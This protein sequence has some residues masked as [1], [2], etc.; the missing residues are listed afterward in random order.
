M[1]FRP[2]LFL[3]FISYLLSSRVMGQPIQILDARTQDKIAFVHLVLDDSLDVF[4]D[5]EGKYTFHKSWYSVCLK[6]PYYQTACFSHAEGIPDTIFLKPQKTSTRINRSDEASIHLIKSI[7]MRRESL[8]LSTQQ[9]SYKSYNKFTLSGEKTGKSN[10]FFKKILN[11]LSY[12]LESFDKVHLFL[13]ESVSEKHHKNKIYYK[14]KITGL[15]STGIK[16]PLTYTNL[17][18]PSP[19]TIYN[20]YIS[21][22]TTKYVS[23]LCHAGYVTYA[24][25]IKDTAVIDG[26]TLFAVRFY[27]HPA[28]SINALQGYL[29]IDKKEQVVRYFVA[30]PIKQGNVKFEAAEEFEKKEGKWVPYIYRTDIIMRNFEAGKLKLTAS[31]KSIIFDYQFGT[32][33]E[34]SYFNEYVLEYD[35][36]ATHVT[37]DVWEQYRQME[38]TAKD[39]A[40]F[41]FFDST[42]IQKKQDEVLKFGERVYYGEIPVGKINLDLNR[43]I[44]L[45]YLEGLRLGLGFHTNYKFSP[46]LRTGG[47]FGYGFKDQKW[48]YGADISYK[49]RNPYELSLGV[50]VRHDI[51]EAGAQFFPFDVY[52]YSSEPLRKYKL[53]I[54]DY[55]NESSAYISFRPLKYLRVNTALTIAENLPAYRY[56]YKDMQSNRFAYTELSAGFRYSFGEQYIKT[57]SNNL[58]I[59]SSYPIFWFNYTRG[60]NDPIWGQ[61]SYSRFDFKL[62]QTFNIFRY[63]TSGIQL[64][65][66]I[67]TGSP[68]YSKLYN[69]RGSF[70]EFS[71]VIH[72]SFETM[73]YNEFLSD[74]FF[75]L[76]YSHDFGKIYSPNPNFRPNIVMVH[77]FGFG[78]LRHP[79]YQK[80]IPF[81]TMQKGFF[82]SGVFLKNLMIINL[83]G[84]RTG[85]GFGVFSRYG[86]YAAKKL[87]RNI[88][89]K[90]SANFLI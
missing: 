90:L 50:S 54:L 13:L 36:T 86:P 8:Q 68:P 4:S 71:V 81:K 42:G 35:S 69:M 44:N 39:S 25:Q 22:A 31:A 48:K 64:V 17:L 43:I 58:Y 82:E 53:S 83:S 41:Y 63:G 45:N 77:N 19:F 62:Q 9:F 66:G 57:P 46:H 10:K 16:L 49:F 75:A 23:P 6:S 65:A 76:F 29:Y 70:R 55:I 18:H 2:S 60:I 20:N 11:L 32:T 80:L 33:K 40:T 12:D 26:D 28:R 85:L 47:Y 24:Y 52:Q 67:T 27:P 79:E 5:L 74:R 84:L 14:E 72:N 61:F 7:L 15:N 34:N 87:S 38:L 37:S 88:V 56:Q 59:G 51:Y 30:S 73:R 3:L 21:I 78:S 1:I 89:F